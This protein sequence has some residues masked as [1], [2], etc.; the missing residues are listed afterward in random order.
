MRT[1]I[2][3]GSFDPFTAGHLDVLDSALKLFDK[4]IVAVGYNSN[5]AA[6]FFPVDIRM[7]IIRDS[8]KQYGKRVAVCCYTGLTI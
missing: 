1:A 6:G 2:F 7:K 3:P 4:V 5:K 8:I